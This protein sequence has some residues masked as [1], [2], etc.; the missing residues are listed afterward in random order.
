LTVSSLGFGST[1][2][3]CLL[4]GFRS[5]I[6]MSQAP[7][8]EQVAAPRVFH[9]HR[10]PLAACGFR[11]N[12]RAIEQALASMIFHLLPW[13]VGSIVVRIIR[14]CANQPPTSGAFGAGNPAPPKASN[15]EQAR[16]LAML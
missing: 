2:L 11:T 8:H 7:V 12:R 6:F 10:H 14:Q 16:P 13:V 1:L 5:S 9:L 3:T 15:C 4:C